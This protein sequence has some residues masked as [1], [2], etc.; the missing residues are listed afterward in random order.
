MLKLSSLVFILAQACT[1]IS[2]YP[3][4]GFEE[5]VEDAIQER[6]GIKIDFTGS[7]LET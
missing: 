3:D 4:N 2:E 6:T 7:T 1:Y 5:I